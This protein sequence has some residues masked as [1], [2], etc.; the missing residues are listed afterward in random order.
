VGFRDLKRRLTASI[1][2][3]DAHRLQDR[4]RGLGLTPLA[5]AP[6]R[7]PIRVGGEITKIRVVPRA[8][9]PSLE[10]TINDGTGEAVAIFLGRRSLGGCDHGRGLLLEG[11]A[12]PERGRPVL[13]NPAYTLLPRG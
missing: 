1:E 9:S 12:H 2:E 10:V 5:E 4:Y 8:G 3:I 7:V 13:L 6:D 11:V